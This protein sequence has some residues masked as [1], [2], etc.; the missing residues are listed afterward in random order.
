MEPKYSTKIIKICENCDERDLEFKKCSGCE[1]VYYCSI[2]CQKNHWDEH[3]K[4]CGKHCKYP[5][6]LN[7]LKKVTSWFIK[8]LDLPPKFHYWK[9][10]PKNKFIC[11]MIDDVNKLTYDSEKICNIYKKMFHQMDI[12]D[13]YDM[14]RNCNQYEQNKHHLNK[15]EQNRSRYIPFLI[16]IKTGDQCQ[17]VMQ[18]VDRYS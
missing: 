17:S 11:I 13:L 7:N 18:V 6:S 3:K 16:M 4:S 15:Y 14:L 10:L 9:K 5:G 1:N 12:S 2:E 8:L